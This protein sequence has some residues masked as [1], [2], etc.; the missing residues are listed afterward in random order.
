MLKP[1]IVNKGKREKLPLIR[2]P[3][4]N[5]KKT[6]LGLEADS[7]LL[8]KC[9]LYVV[10][11]DTAYIYLN[12]LLYMITTMVKNAADL[13][14]P[15]VNWIPRT[16][17]V[18]VLQEAWEKLDYPKA[19]VTS[20]TI[21]GTI[22]VL[23]TVSCAVAGYAFARLNVPLKNF[24]FFCLL[25]TFIVPPQLTVLPKILAASQFGLFGTALPFVLPAAFGLGLKGALFVIIY[26]QF[27]STQPKEL[28]EA[29]KMDGAGAFK[30]FYKVMLPLAKPAIIVVFLFSFVWNWNDSYNPSVFM[31]GAEHLPLSVGITR[32]NEA[33]AAEAEMFGPSLYQDPLKMATAFLI[34]LPTLLIYIFAQ[35][36]FVESVDRTGLVE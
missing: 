3:L 16:I 34:I 35:R 6:V 29:A 9:F 21:S 36:W 25:L 20:L 31:R 28:E 32:M 14:D 11:I 13:M 5:L 10:L 27:F 1:W 12:P 19:F 17:Y 33:L 23:Q 4:H 15:A 2:A 8:F 7:G 30:V 24:W 22:A 26:R 18:G